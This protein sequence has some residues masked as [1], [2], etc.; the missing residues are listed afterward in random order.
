MISR[1]PLLSGTQQEHGGIIKH[2]AKLLYALAEATVP[3]LTVITRK[4][5]VHQQQLPLSVDLLSYL[6]NCRHQ[7]PPTTFLG[8]PNDPH[9]SN[10][11]ILGEKE[12]PGPGD[13]FAPQN[14]ETCST[15][16]SE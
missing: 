5:S 10:A 11:H 3:K 8:S 14:K 13:Q 9:I 4:V 2:G 15:S 16:M 12:P 1:D 7:P 6:P